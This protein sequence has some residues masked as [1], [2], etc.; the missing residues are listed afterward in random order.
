MQATEFD[1]EAERRAM[2]Y[3]T[4]DSVQTMIGRGCGKALAGRATLGEA[5]AA[6]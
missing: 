1:V 3:Q 2:K 5:K 4:L 6:R